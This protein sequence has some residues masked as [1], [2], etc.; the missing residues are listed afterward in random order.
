MRHVTAL[1]CGFLL[2]AGC[3]GS[4]DYYGS[5]TP[6]A[7]LDDVGYDSEEID[8]IMAH[9]APLS[10]YNMDLD[11]SASVS[12]DDLRAVLSLVASDPVG[13]IT[14]VKYGDKLAELIV[15]PGVLDFTLSASVLIAR[16]S[17]GDDSL[18]TLCASMRQRYLERFQAAVDVE[19]RESIFILADDMY[20]YAD[21]EASIAETQVGCAVKYYLIAEEYWRETDDGG[22]AAEISR[23]LRAMRYYI[24]IGTADGGK[25]W[26]VYVR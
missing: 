2:L 20:S 3:A 6:L 12:E 25:T 19:V 21:G 18:I 23:L 4:T 7:Y 1:V 14:Y 8:N 13:G 22:A 16:N 9:V 11:R 26:I 5:R 24:P 15:T 10:I 17:G